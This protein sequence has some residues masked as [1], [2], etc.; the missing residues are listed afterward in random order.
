MGVADSYRPVFDVRGRQFERA[1][2]GR[3]GT[4]ADAGGKPG[5]GVHAIRT[6]AAGIRIDGGKPDRPDPVPLGGGVRGAELPER[7]DPET[8]LSEFVRRATCV[9]RL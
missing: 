4:P 8:V 7:R 1:P 2:G 9:A 6:A 3:R 5:R